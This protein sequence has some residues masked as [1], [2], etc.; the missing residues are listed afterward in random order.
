MNVKIVIQLICK[1]NTIAYQVY[2]Y[3]K[4]FINKILNFKVILKFNI[5][6][7]YFPKQKMCDQKFTQNKGIITKNNYPI[8]DENTL[9]RAQIEVNSEM[10]IKAYIIDMRIDP[11]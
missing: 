10:I 4:T 2:I 8:Y 7:A 11:V 3:L 9:C 1:L 5:F 6:I